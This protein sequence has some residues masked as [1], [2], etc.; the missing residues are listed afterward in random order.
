MPAAA[1]FSRSSFALSASA[2]AMTWMTYWVLSG[3]GAD[4]GAG[5]GGVALAV[6]SGAG[7]GAA[8]AGGALGSGFGSAAGAGGVALGAGG[9][10][11]SLGENA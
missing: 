5:L 1:I 6:F 10:A 3:L 8:A 11:A 9:S 4:G 2:S 7:F